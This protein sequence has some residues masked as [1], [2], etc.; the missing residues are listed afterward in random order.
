[1]GGRTTRR[2][3]VA[4]A[5]RD[6]GGGG[7]APLVVLHGLLGSSRNWAS[8]GRRLA[9]HFHVFALDLRNH[10]DSPHARGMGFPDLARDVL[11]WL[12]RRGLER[13]HLMGHSLGGKVAMR[14]ACDY[15]ERLDLLFLLD[16]APRDYPPAPEI[17]DAMA[18]L[19]VASLKRRGEAQEALAEAIPDTATRLFVLTNLVRAPDGNG[20]RWQVDLEE[21]RRERASMSESPLDP[22]EVYRGPT[23]LVAGQ[24][25]PYVKESDE[26]LLRSHFPAIEIRRLE[27]TG[28][29]VH[30]ESP[31]AFVEAVVEFA[32]H[33]AER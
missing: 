6:Y 23:Q 19:D 7:R 28:H 18:G 24:R 31:D 8:A 3:T 32:R 10:G 33:E 30:A 25:S 26:E 15:A 27:K 17:L 20:F 14:F 4:L 22:G 2:R 11:A 5:H 13:V 12:D 9:E 1:M 29:D 16:I 21:L